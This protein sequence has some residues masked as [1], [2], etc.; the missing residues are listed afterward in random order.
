M[1]NGFPELGSSFQ[2]FNRGPHV[3]EA[4]TSFDAPSASGASDLTVV[5]IKVFELAEIPVSETLMK[6]GSRGMS[7]RGHRIS[8]IHAGVPSAKLDE[9]LSRHIVEKIAVAR[10]TGVVAGA[11]FNAGSGMFGPDLRIPLRRNQ[12]PLGF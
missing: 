6:P 7:A 8:G 3:D 1:A 4:L 10:R 11:A 5:V 12:F 2:I 9:C